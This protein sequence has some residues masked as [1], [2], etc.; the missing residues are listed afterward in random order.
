MNPLNTTQFDRL[1]K[2]VDWSI[3]QLETP[4]RKRIEAI[5]QFTGSHYA[6]GG[7]EKRV[8]V[9]FIKLAVDIYVRQLAA[10]APRVLISTRRP[11]LRATAANLELAINQIPGEI[12]LAKTLRKLVTEALFAFG[13]AKVG[14]HT[15]G[16]VLGHD[17]GET[18]VDLVTLDDYFIDA[19]V[20]RRDLIQYEG[21]DYWL[22]YDEVM[23]SGWIPKDK[24][25]DIKPDDYT[26][27]GPCGEERAESVSTD[28]SAD[29]FKDKLWLRDVW[30]PGD[31][32]MVTYA[33]K[34]G[35][36]LKTVEWEGPK[37]SPYYTL[38]FSDVPGNL[39]PLA[40]VA[41]WRDL[42]EL[43]NALFRKLAD[44]ADS[45]KTVLGFPGGQDEDVKAFGSARDGDGIK[46]EGQEPKVL[47]A[48]G[49]DQVGLAFFLQSRDLNSYFGGNIDSL[50]GLSPM[51]ET[52]GQD[53]LLG[54]AASAQLRDMA[55]MVVD[56]ARDVFRAISWYEWHNPVGSR[57]LEKPIP[58]TDLTIPVAWNR[59]SRQ[60]DFS[61]YDLD[62][63]VYSLQ[64]TS[65]G[66]QLQKLGQ[67][68][69]QYVLPLAPLIQ[70][71][72]GTIDVQAIMRLVSKYADLPELAEVVQFLQQDATTGAENTGMPQHTTR[73]YERVNRPG[74][75]DRGKSQIL[76]QALLGGKPQQ[77]EAASLGR[78]TS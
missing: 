73:T 8:P 6:D 2:S 17:Y 55:D 10:R 61:L 60:G 23:E 11:D 36:R 12:G 47:K 31:N 5:R 52:V 51:T 75:T 74:A 64:D 25:D 62:I 35:T 3:R 42:H 69:Q 37:H 41:I 59:K 30:L 70:Q 39:F 29:L 9:N 15:V 45:Q 77:A 1:R 53:R 71:Q 48:G 18:F 7:S 38:G 68:I 24:R 50:G 4:K 49:V 65:P 16:Q 78:V 32:I 33:V 63:D 67:V 43:G 22:P 27:T 26:L 56:F 14:L 28:E 76:Q 66:L 57:T 21:N 44:Q 58:G 72:G 54:E 19:S 40:P 34:S 46:Y 20:K 13:V